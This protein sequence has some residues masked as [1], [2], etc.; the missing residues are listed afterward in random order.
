M[1]ENGSRPRISVVPNI[2]DQFGR[3]TADGLPVLQDEIEPRAPK[4]VRDA[5][6]QSRTRGAVFNCEAGIMWRDD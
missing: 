4:D 3:T 6:E 5:I 2:V 1:T